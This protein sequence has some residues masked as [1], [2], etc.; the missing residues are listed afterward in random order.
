MKE[1][2]KG[3]FQ[4]GGHTQRRK[5]KKD[6]NWNRELWQPV[7]KMA[8]S[9]LS[10]WHSGSFV[11][12]SHIEPE[13]VCTTKRIGQVWCTSLL[14]LSH[15]MTLWHLL[16]LGL[17]ALRGASC[18]VKSRSLTKRPMYWGTEVS[19]NNPVNELSCKPVFQLCQDLDDYCPSLQLL[20]PVRDLETAPPN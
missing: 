3:P 19:G 1:S 15:K 17:I 2:Q 7:S 14:R 9:D 18:H 8:P 10:S 5:K 13:L 20:N 6:K 4:K 11:V 12:P 16:C